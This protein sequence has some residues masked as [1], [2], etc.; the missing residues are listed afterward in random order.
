MITE[1]M[2]ERLNNL[3]AKYSYRDYRA[4]CMK[5]R[6]RAK[7]Y[8]LSEATNEAREMRNLALKRDAATL[9]DE[10]RIKLYLTR[11]L[12]TG[13]MNDILEFEKGEEKYDP[14]RAYDAV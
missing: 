7:S 8:T 5:Q 4:A 9:E 14:A 10:G 11:K 3:V 2:I 13:E 6:R 12:M 1:H